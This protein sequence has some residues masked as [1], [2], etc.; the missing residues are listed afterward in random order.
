MGLT[1]VETVKLA[2]VGD[3]C[4]DVYDGTDKAYPGGNPVNVA[5]YTAR[6]GGKAS[7]TGVV[8]DDRYGELMRAALAEKGVDVS[9]L[10]TEAGPT[11]IT[12]VNVV[13]GDRILGEYE[14]GV[15]ADFRLTSEDIDFLCAHDAVVTGLWG[16]VEKDLP[17]IKAR[18]VPVAFDFAD[19]P[20][21]QTLDAAIPFVDYAFF[22]RD[23]GT[24]A[25]MEA[26]LRDMRRRGPKITVVTMG[27]RG[28]MCYDGARFYRQGVVA[29]TVA[30]TMGAGDSYIAG[31]LH[32]LLH[33]A[34]IPE[35]MEKGA[36]NS[37]VT[38][39]YHGAWPFDSRY[40]L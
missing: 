5:V 40:N 3:N 26:F 25:E 10:R 22:S 36:Q 13:G 19:K 8:G 39:Q 12:H 11:A 34:A 18:G 33:G 15:M 7:Y 38:L 37:G 1:H 6:L 23:E 30:D 16:M 32:G 9:H 21:H 20:E 27:E 29:C 2:A 17:A 24:A 35:C 14:K 31:F 4:M 28:S